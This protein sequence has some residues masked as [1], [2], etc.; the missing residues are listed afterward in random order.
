M[1]SLIVLYGQRYY[2]GWDSGNPGGRGAILGWG[3][4]QLRKL[5][6]GSIAVAVLTRKTQFAQPDWQKDAVQKYLN[7]LPS[8]Q[9]QGLF[10]P[11]VSFFPP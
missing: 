2:G 9:Y 10:N 5:E 3:F 1:F 8:G 11:W 4:Q 7:N 6:P